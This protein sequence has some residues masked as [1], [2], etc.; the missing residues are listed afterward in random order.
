[1]ICQILKLDV[2]RANK[3]GEACL[4]NGSVEVRFDYNTKAYLVVKS[5]WISRKLKTYN[6]GKYDD[7]KEAID[8]ALNNVLD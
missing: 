4:S 2:Y 6:L 7:M 5:Y 1:M 3:P 8:A